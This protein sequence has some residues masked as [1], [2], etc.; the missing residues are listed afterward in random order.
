MEFVDP[1]K[2][3]DQIKAIKDHFT[4]TFLSRFIAF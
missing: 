4:E 1:I 3:I 2:E